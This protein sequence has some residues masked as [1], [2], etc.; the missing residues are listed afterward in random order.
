MAK[1]LRIAMLSYHTCPLASQEGK[2]T[3]G[4]NVYVL[5]LSKSLARLGHHVDIFTRCQDASNLARIEIEPRVTLYH[6][7]GGPSQML[8]KKDLIQYIPEFAQNVLTIMQ[9]QAGAYDILHC[10]YYMSGMAG[11]D[12]QKAFN[13]APKLIMTFHTLALMKN[14]IARTESEQEDE[15]RIRAEIELAHLADCVITPS[16]SDAQYMAYLYDVS[17]EKITLIPPGVDIDRFKPIDKVLAKQAIQAKPDQRIILFVGR[18]EPLKGIDVLMYAIKIM[19]SKNPAMMVCLW[20]VGGDVSQ[21]SH[22]WSEELQKL[23]KLRRQLNLVANVHLVGQKNQTELLYYYNA[24]EVVVMPSHYESFGMVAAEA[25]A[26]GIP[27]ITTNVSGISM[28]LDPHHQSLITTVNNPLL[29]ASQI[30]H[31]LTNPDQYRASSQRLR[32]TVQDLR[33]E[34]VAAK[35]T[36]AYRHSLS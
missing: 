19:L 22:L 33:W 31:V 17:P 2:E 5:E 13:I 7:V 4:M 34:S 10:H 20:V 14:L 9:A 6:V 16:E 35:M 15:I 24:S 27:V 8:P 11:I 32:E 25:L 36:E 3:G 12:I 23:E 21:P 26:C 30:E 29:L 28:L 18:I 1:K